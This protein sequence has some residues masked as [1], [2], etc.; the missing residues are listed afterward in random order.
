MQSLL[1]LVSNLKGTY[2]NKNLP[3]ILKQLQDEFYINILLSMMNNYE[4]ELHSDERL[5]LYKN[6]CKVKPAELMAARGFYWTTWKLLAKQRI[7]RAVLRDDHRFN[8]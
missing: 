7:K 6:A 3:L 4:K 5:K 8:P 1:S 2:C